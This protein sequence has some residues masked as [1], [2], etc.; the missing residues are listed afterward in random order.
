MEFQLGL[1]WSGLSR[2]SGSVFGAPLALETI[3]AFFVESTFL[4]LWIF[5][6][7]RLNWW[8]HLALIWVVTLTAY[9]SAYFVL[10]ATG[11]LQRPVGFEMVDGMARLTDAGALLTYRPARRI[12]PGFGGSSVAEQRVASWEPW[13][14]PRTLHQRPMRT[15]CARPGGSTGSW[16]GTT[17]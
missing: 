16:S 10:V 17:G 1:N 5:G 7:D 14:R 8:V 2:V 4:G 9:L 12:G 11:W 6:R 13:T 15:C 3:I